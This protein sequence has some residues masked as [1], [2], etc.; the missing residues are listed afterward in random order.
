MN[1][2][3]ARHAI[4]IFLCAAA[5][6]APAPAASV[7]QHNPSDFKA[8]STCVSTRQASGEQRTQRGLWEQSVYVA[9][10]CAQPINLKICYSFSDECI[11]VTAVP[12]QETQHQ[13][14]IKN[15]P[16]FQYTVNSD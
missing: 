4:Q 9:N 16:T 14:G 15:Q 11:R 7:Q 8:I 6:P 12:G 5:L 10:R 3:T 13:L 2:L 1:H